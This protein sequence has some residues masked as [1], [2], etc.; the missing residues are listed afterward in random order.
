MPTTTREAATRGMRA[1]S[2]DGVIPPCGRASAGADA[3]Y[4]PC[5]A[6]MAHRRKAPAWKLPPNRNALSKQW[7]ASAA[8]A[9]M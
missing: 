8:L 6:A 7:V 9:Y 2:R 1:M 3:T 4:E 5:D